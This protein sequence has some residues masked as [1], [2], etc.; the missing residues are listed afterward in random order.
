MHLKALHQHRC[1]LLD[2]PQIVALLSQSPTQKM[3]SATRLHPDS[4]D[5]HIGRICQQLSART[6]FPNHD[7]SARIN[8]YQ[9]KQG[10]A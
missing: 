8:A 4:M 5:A 10:L 6:S 3:R 2:C 1:L 7:C 9:V